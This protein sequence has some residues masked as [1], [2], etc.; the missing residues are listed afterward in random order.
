MCVICIKK[1]PYPYFFFMFCV[2]VKKKGMLYVCSP[3]DLIGSTVEQIVK[4]YH[5]KKGTHS[6]LCISMHIF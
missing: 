6:H 5:F 1:K 2:L 3:N 4:L